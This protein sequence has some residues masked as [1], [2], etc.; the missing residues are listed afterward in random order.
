M[1]EL[2]TS[3]LWMSALAAPPAV[4]GWLAASAFVRGAP[5]SARV[6]TLAA[7]VLLWA[8]VTFGMQALGTL[9]LL[10]RGP[11]AIWG[12]VGLALGW[13]VGSLGRRRN[14]NEPM[15]DASVPDT[16]GEG[17]GRWDLPSILGL[18][19]TLWGCLERGLLSLV[20]P[21][22]VVSDAPIYHLYFAARWWQEGRLSLIASPFGETAA[23]YFPAN[24]DL[25]FS[26]LIAGWGGDRLA[27]VGQSPFLLLAA[28][29]V[30]DLARR[31]GACASAALLAVC[32]L[33]ATVPL[34]LWSF[35]AIADTFVVAGY[36]V[37]VA[38]LF[39]YAAREAGAGGLLVAGLAAGLAWGCK[40]TSIV[41]I[42]PLLALGLVLILQ[43][44]DTSPRTRL[45]RAALLVGSAL[46]PAA[47]W[48]ARN[49]WLTGNPLYPLHVEAFGRVWLRG[50]YDT[51]AMQSSPF[52][53]P[54]AIWP[55]LVDT[56]VVVIDPRLVPVWLAAVLGAWAIGRPKGVRAAW[57][58]GCAALAVANVALFWLVIPYRTQ[59]RF[60]LHAVGLAAVPLALL[61]AR[62]AWV[63]WLGLVLLA[64][65]MLTHFAW[66]FAEPSRH[67][68]WSLT[69][70]IPSLEDAVIVVPLDAESLRR[71]LA[72]RARQPLLVFR[73]ACGVG[74]LVLAGLWAWAARRRTRGAAGLALGAALLAVVTGAGWLYR[75]QGGDQIV[76]PGFD[77]YRAAWIALEGVAPPGGTRIA[78]AG[79]NLPY[80]LMGKGLRNRVAYVNIDRHDGWLLHDYHRMAAARGD[81]TLWPTP[82]PGW[83]RL[84]P[85][86]DA[87]LANLARRGIRVLVVARANPH[88]GPFNLADP[89]GFPVERRWAED[90]PDLFPPIYGVDP[91]DPRI[92]IYGV[93]IP[94][95]RRR[96]AARRATN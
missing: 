21:V 75:G 53:I 7:G 82:R 29:A 14:R 92:R 6:R 68:P 24:G 3:L 30:H 50:W 8:W 2:A 12:L 35:E 65:H 38:F 27:R 46:L 31:A 43:R 64:V 85:D 44:G 19:L 70:Q 18:G 16:S 58:W 57:G 81:P 73:A 51:G 56:V 55:A 22:K 54:R 78:Y 23:P 77:N 39:R 71:A 96:N 15:A 45:A 36:L 9:G 47:Y 42:P 76:Y 17:A 61:F 26:W 49:A 79:T 90:H 74:A 94:E 86:F 88:D 89:E 80:Y 69:K 5:A 83:D 13:A 20:F 52:Y 32:W 48:Y 62:G 1:A 84:H 34:L 59:Q 91:P 60:M 66:P 11:L 37:C 93:R 4:G 87:W 28:L 72:D 25:W 41:F 33:V 63:R 40:A 67:A 95:Q 10:A